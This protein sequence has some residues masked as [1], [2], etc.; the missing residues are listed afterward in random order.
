LIFT[1]A[2]VNVAL[3]HKRVNAATRRDLDLSKPLVASTKS[4]AVF[5]RD[6][7]GS[8]HTLRIPTA[9]MYAVI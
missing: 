9:A 5:R 2:I 4:L 8:L 1:R 6:S 7:F 3:V